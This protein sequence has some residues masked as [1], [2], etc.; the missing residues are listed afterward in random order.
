LEKT[1]QPV[2]ENHREG[3]LPIQVTQ[4]GQY[5]IGTHNE[6]P[7]AI[8]AIMVSIVRSIGGYKPLFPIPQTP[9]AFHQ[10]AQ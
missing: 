10:L 2:K 9:S 7:P 6:T 4:R 8:A 3:V 5:F 1:R